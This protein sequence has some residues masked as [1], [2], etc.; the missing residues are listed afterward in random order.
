MGRVL[1]PQV[2]EEKRRKKAEAA[3]KKQEQEVMPVGAGAFP[4]RHYPWGPAG[5]PSASVH[6]RCPPGGRQ[7]LGKR[8]AEGTKL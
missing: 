1:S 2:E 4:G 5:T 6:Q 7:S 8:S 3:R